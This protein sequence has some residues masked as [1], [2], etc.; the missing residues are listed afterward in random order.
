MDGVNVA[1]GSGVSVGVLVLVGCGV[2]V[3]VFDGTVVG[4]AVGVFVGTLVG[5][6][7]GVL[8]GTGLGVKVGDG[9]MVGVSLGRTTI[10]RNGVLPVASVVS[11]NHP[12]NATTATAPRPASDL[13]AGRRT[14]VLVARFGD[15]GP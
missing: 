12:S 13:L 6:L 4:V 14:A 3:G 11:T 15:S 8:L 2:S 9:V 1:V 5:V 7:V 10:A